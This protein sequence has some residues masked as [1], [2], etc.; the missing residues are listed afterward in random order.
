MDTNRQRGDADVRIRMRVVQRPRW[1][2]NDRMITRRR[3]YLMGTKYAQSGSSPIIG[4]L[5]GE[6]AL[7]MVP[8]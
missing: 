7:L 3:V 2:A 5:N 1:K 8:T 4:S 6:R